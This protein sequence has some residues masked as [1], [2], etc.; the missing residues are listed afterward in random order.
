MRLRYRFALGATLFTLVLI[1]GANLLLARQVPEDWQQAED[2]L[3]GYLLTVG[4]APESYGITMPDLPPVDE[5]EGAP[6]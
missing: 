3:Q 1:L 6:S 2:T 4:A 5:T